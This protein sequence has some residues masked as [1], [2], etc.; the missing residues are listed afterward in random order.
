ME[1]LLRLKRHMHQHHRRNFR[2]PLL[3]LSTL[4]ATLYALR[5][6]AVGKGDAQEHRAPAARNRTS[7]VLS[8]LPPLHV[9]T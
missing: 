9:R 8:F 5:R 3:L 1:T 7:L 4:G 6:A 2:A